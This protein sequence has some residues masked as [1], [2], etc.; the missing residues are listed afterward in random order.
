MIPVGADH[1]P[2]PQRR[3]RLALLQ[4]AAGEFGRPGSALG[5]RPALMEEVR[6]VGITGAILIE[7]GVRQ[8]VPVEGAS[9]FP[10]GWARIAAQG[11]AVDAQVALTKPAQ[12]PSDPEDL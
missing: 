4:G 6:R 10:V 7:G 12:P 5:L 9:R 1:F 11:D 2:Q 8:F 3:V